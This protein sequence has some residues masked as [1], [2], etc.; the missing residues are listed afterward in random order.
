M[1]MRFLW[2]SAKSFC[3]SCNSSNAS[4]WRS[5]SLLIAAICFLYCSSD[6]LPLLRLSLTIF[7]YFIALICS[8]ID[9]VSELYFMTSENDAVALFSSFCWLSL[10]RSLRSLSTAL[11]LLS[12][13]FWAMSATCCSVKPCCFKLCW[14]FWIAIFIASNFDWYAMSLCFR[15]DLAASKYSIAFFSSS[16]LSADWLYFIAPSSVLLYSSFRFFLS[17]SAFAASFSSSA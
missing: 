1:S 2:L 9:F 8:L 6:I 10:S 7:R 16:K 11:A 17:A 5:I 15:R 3:L 4:F 12:A 13:A 14:C